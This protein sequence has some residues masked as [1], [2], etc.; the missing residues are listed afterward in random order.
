MMPCA[1]LVTTSYLYVLFSVSF[2]DVLFHHK[3]YSMVKTSVWD[4]KMTMSIARSFDGRGPL[5]LDPV[6]SELSL[7]SGKVF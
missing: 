6:K 5:C 2:I 3:V 4:V 7:Y 1:P